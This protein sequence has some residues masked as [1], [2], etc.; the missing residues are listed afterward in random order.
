MSG[1]KSR[2]I[3]L[4]FLFERKKK[5]KNSIETDGAAFLR[6]NCHRRLCGFF[7][8]IRISFFLLG[9]VGFILLTVGVHPETY[10]TALVVF[11]RVE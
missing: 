1:H 9:V 6:P 11:A 4:P 5:T 8:T 2:R 10:V 3:K 7:S